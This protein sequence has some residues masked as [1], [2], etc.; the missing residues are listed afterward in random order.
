M[1]AARLT[2][3]TKDDGR[4]GL[5]P[6]LPPP[7][8]L[9]QHGGRQVLSSPPPPPLLPPAALNQDGGVHLHGRQGVSPPPPPAPPTPSSRPYPGWWCQPSWPPGPRPSLASLRSPVQSKQAGHREGSGSR[10]QGGIRVQGTG[11]DQG[12][13]HREGSGSRVQ[14]RGGPPGTRHTTT[15]LFK[16]IIMPAARVTSPPLQ[17]PGALPRCAYPPPLSA[18]P[19]PRSRPSPSPLSYD[20]APVKLSK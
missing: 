11:G 2:W 14:G 7:A 17:P 12:P 1:P 20:N 10:A 19:S 18:L 3:S 15:R 8:A 13:G 6:S 4:Q 16:S 9:T 5:S